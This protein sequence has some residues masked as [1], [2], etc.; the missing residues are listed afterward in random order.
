MEFDKNE[1]QKIDLCILLDDFLKESK[2]LWALAV[3]LV[4]ICSAG[5][6][7]LQYLTYSPSY[8]ATASFTVK[9]A[10][11]LYASV[12]TYNTDTAEQMAKTFPYIM[13]SSVLQE[14]IMAHLDISYMPSVNVRSTSGSSILTITVT[15]SDPQRA[16]D[17]LNAVITYYPEIAEYVVG[18]TV[19]VLLDESGVPTQ[20]VNALSLIG[21]LK[22]GA[23]TGVAAWLLI[24]IGL[25]ILNRT[26]H[27]EEE[28]TR[29]LNIPCTGHIPLIKVSRKV[30]TPLILRSSRNSIFFESIQQ[31]RLRIGKLMDDQQKKVIL[32]SS[33]IPGEG[34]TT[35]ATNLATALAHRGKKVLLID[36]DLRNPSVSR[37]LGIS[38][39]NSLID[40]L[41]GS[42]PIR[43][44]LHSTDVKNLVILPGG[45]GEKDNLKLLTQDRMH[46]LIHASRQLFD[47]VILDTAPCSLLSDAAEIAKLADCGLLVVR[48][49]YASQ[50]QI[51]DGVQRLGD[52]HLPIIGCVLNCVAKSFSTRY[53][54]GYDYGYGYG[55]GSDKAK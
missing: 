5:L 54:Y 31:I 48:Q 27:N 16:Y 53:G 33:A 14:R 40:Y 42:I 43:S 24:V 51:L 9:V 18:S 52:S 26:V 4:T 50:D 30:S 6:M 45:S 19:L 21:S 11:P 46:Q 25:A 34:K 1:E 35:I 28:L 44:L 37:V 36:C 39:N 3:L 8:A 13:T 7:G 32:V 41:R 23:L 49:N 17:V 38:N 20:P 15:D 22:K 29:I 10:N 12:S 55:Y 2:R 47:Y